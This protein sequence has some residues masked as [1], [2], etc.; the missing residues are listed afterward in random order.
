MALTQT[1]EYLKPAKLAEALALKAE[2]GPRAR[3][4]AGGTDLV[5]N[6]DDETVD[7]ELI[8]DLKGIGELG[9]LE[10]ADKRL[11]IGALATFS[12]LLESAAVKK[13]FPL[14]W[15]AAGEVASV[16]VRNR[17]T[18][19]GNLCSCVPCLDS[20]PPLLLYEASVALAGPGGNREIPIADFLRGPRRTALNPDEAV[21]GVSLPEVP[22]KHGAAF[23]KLK[24]YRGEDLAQASVGVIALP[25]NRWRV[26][27]GSVNP[28][29]IRA[30][31][32]EKTLQGKVLSP[33]RISEAVKLVKETVA[34][35]TDVRAGREYR[36]HMC[37]VMLERAL[38]AAAARLAGKGP[39]YGTSLI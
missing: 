18:M 10:S 1:F 9:G 7:P 26:A 39:A 21:T 28:T 11:R 24:R 31:K 23:I 6:L 16:S 32:I 3:F 20:G 5:N 30:A 35:L 25:G 8:I 29:P 2:F 15:E 34:P 12:E 33:Q 37:E 38:K 4:L 14:L 22:G 27:F 36:L 13:K 17:A 19:V